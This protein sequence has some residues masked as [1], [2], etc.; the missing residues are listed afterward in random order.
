[1]SP[2]STLTR[3]TLTCTTDTSTRAPIL[4]EPTIEREQSKREPEGRGWK[5][6]KDPKPG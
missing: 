1:M 5:V 4:T 6:M 3:I 2:S